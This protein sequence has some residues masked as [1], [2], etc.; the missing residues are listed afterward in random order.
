M[1]CRPKGVK[2][3][4]PVFP[5]FFI[6]LA[7]PPSPPPPPPFDGGLSR[8]PEHKRHDT[9]YTKGQSKPVKTVTLLLRHLCRLS[10]ATLWKLS[11]KNV[12]ID[13]RQD[14]P[15]LLVLKHI[16]SQKV[17]LPG[18]DIRQLLVDTERKMAIG[19]QTAT[20]AESVS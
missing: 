17:I 5:I 11:Q 9:F 1:Q 15:D 8:W 4:K 13:C 19:I 18:A 7:S 20:Y 2:Q 14:R 3:V 6:E 16:L 10:L 12:S